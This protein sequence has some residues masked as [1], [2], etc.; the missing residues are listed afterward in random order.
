MTM[1]EVS[2]HGLPQSTYVRAA[3]IACH[4][5]R[6]SYDIVVAMSQSPITEITDMKRGA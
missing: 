3:R 5:N 1:A 2:I 4:E 6:V